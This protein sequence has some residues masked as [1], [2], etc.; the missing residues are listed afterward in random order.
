MA[1][2]W[3]QQVESLY[4]DHHGWLKGWLMRRLGCSHHAADVAQDTFVRILGS[5]DA[6]LGVREPRAYLTTTAKHLLISRSRRQVLEQAYLAEL[7]ALASTA[8]G[9][10]SPESILMAVEALEQISAAL[11][12]VAPRVREAFLRHYL[13]GQTQAEVA[14]AVGVSK[15]MV[16]KYLVDALVC[17]RLHCAA[18]R[19][20]GG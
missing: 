5:R 19:H 13:E 12:A 3:E 16:Q 6:L 8:P 2:A 15:R 14:S 11:S 9:H 18:L 10:P 17:C 4:A 1:P 7:A 20:H